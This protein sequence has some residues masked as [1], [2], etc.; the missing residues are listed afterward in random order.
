MIILIIYIL[1]CYATSAGPECLGSN[2]SSASVSEVA[3]SIVM[4]CFNS[5]SIVW[6][7]CVFYIISF[8]LSFFLTWPHC[9]AQTGSKL[10]VCPSAS[11][12]LVLGLLVCPRCA[13]AWMCFRV[14]EPFFLLL[15]ESHNR[16]SA[17]C[18][19]DPRSPRG[20]E[21]LYRPS[22]LSLHPLPG[23]SSRKSLP[24]SKRAKQ[25]SS[26]EFKHGLEVRAIHSPA[27][28]EP[29]SLFSFPAYPAL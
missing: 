23:A 4:P 6:V 1:R 28:K 15:K 17:R 19:L 25:S 9:V 14:P 7:L 10:T 29:N 27:H 22:A 8:L 18:E 2:V 12:S 5:S 13:R 11:L 16:V 26:L 20:R 21:A 24:N 3:E